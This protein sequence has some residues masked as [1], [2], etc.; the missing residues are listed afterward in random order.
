MIFNIKENIF[1]KIENENKMNN[2]NIWARGAA[3]KQGVSFR[4]K[5]IS[6]M[7]QKAQRCIVRKMTKNVRK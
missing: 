4:K 3:S 7:E 6:P 1:N 5:I 2:K